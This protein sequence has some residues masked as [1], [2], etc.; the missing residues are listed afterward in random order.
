MT[1]E[2][3]LM[4]ESRSLESLR[5]LRLRAL[6]RDLVSDEG[7]VRAAE[8]LGV[9]YRTLVRAVES[10]E[11]SGRMSDALERHLLL[12]GGSAAARE[13]ERVEALEQRVEALAEELHGGLEEVRGTVEA[14][15]KAL[16][17]E[18][19]QAV[20]G[21]ERRLAKVEA[22]Q[23]GRG[24]AGAAEAASA[25][26]RPAARAAFRREYPDLVTVDPEPGEEDVYGEAMPL[27]VEWRR[28]RSARRGA[29]GTLAHAV[30]EERMRELELELIGE[31]RL[32]LPPSTWPWDESRRRDEVWERARALDRARV[33]R[34]RAQVR[35]WLHRVLTLGLWWE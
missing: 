30:A 1:G 28:V 4:G 9:S 29:K 6:L 3:L 12:G 23:G 8:L 27:I 17:E 13:R 21:L 32:T 22:W 15:L 16:G 25:V 26:E 31:R 2:E 34:A 19:A 11:L 14:G 18:Q 35:Q 24:D 20:R 10:D 33:E 5:D 7:R